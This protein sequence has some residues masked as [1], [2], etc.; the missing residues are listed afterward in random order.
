MTIHDFMLDTEKVVSE[1]FERKGLGDIK[2][3]QCEI[4]K[5]NDETLHGLNLTPEGQR[6]GWTLYFDDLY[7]R[8]ENGESPAE[9]LEEAAFRCEEVLDY[10]LPAEPESLDLRFESIKDRLT[11]RLI[12]VRKNMR[13]MKG[14]PYIDV[15]CGLALISVINSERNVTSEWAL[16]VTD[17]L[18]RN[19]IRCGRE[20]LLTAALDN[21]V[22]IEPPVLTTLSEC[23][24]SNYVR[25]FRVNNYIE[26]TTD[27]PEDV[28]AAFMLTNK[29]AFFGSAVL[30]YPGVMEKIASLFGCGYYVL[31]SSIHE[32]MIIPDAAGPDVPGMF[33]TVHEANTTVVDHC[34]LLSDDIFHYDPE[35][36]GLKIVREKPEGSVR[37]RPRRG[38]FIA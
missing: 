4:V 28:K 14:R 2:I 35:T 20:E 34:D 37:D 13:Y 11:V 24:Y 3:T 12:G 15:G 17:E 33:H 7:G 21:T 32:V 1:H 26:E 30:F 10:E 16:S 29:S 18:L 6:A 19:E 22:R 38:K 31:P 25:R 36:C 9:L 5:L 27:R 23:V 8:Y